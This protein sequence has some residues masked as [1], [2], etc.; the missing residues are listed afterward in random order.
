MQIQ[1]LQNNV[2]F[3]MAS[4]IPSKRKI[5][6]KLGPY[7]AEQVEIA[8]PTLRDLA[9]DVDIYFEPV[10]SDDVAKKGF[11]IV[12]KQLESNPLK[13]LFCS[14]PYYATHAINYDLM[15]YEEFSKMLVRRAGIAKF[16]FLKYNK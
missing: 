10:P 12:V 14:R 6:K 2:N 8:R 11:N 7:I 16:D 15:G 1:S 13:R 3:G 4:H 9:T 5:A